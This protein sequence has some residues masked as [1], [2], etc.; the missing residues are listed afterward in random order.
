F[1]C[2]RC[3]EPPRAHDQFGAT[4]SV[5]V[6]VHGDEPIDHVTFTLPHALHVD[7]SRA[8]HY[9]ELRRVMNQVC[10]LGTPDLVL[11]GQTIDVWAGA[12]DPSPFYDGGPVPGLGQVPGQV[13]ATLTTAQDE[14]F[15]VFWL[16][17]GYLTKR[18]QCV[19]RRETR[20]DK[21]LIHGHRT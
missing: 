20:K 17:H 14:G 10:D 13:F 16:T 4:G 21:V 15:I 2:F 9:A 11:A 3:D 18:F 8:H 6:Q 12:T 5:F 19:L 7:G 1:Q